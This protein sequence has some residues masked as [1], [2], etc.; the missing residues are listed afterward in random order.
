MLV[1]KDAIIRFGLLA[2]VLTLLAWLPKAG[3]DLRDFTEAPK[4]VATVAGCE[5]Y[6]FRD[7]RGSEYLIV[8]GVNCTVTGGG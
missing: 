8:K 7:E 2:L 4:L 3:K 1:A 6:R 5:A